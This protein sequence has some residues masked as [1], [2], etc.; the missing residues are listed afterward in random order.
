MLQNNLIK[1][2]GMIFCKKFVIS[3]I[4]VHL[5]IRLLLKKCYK[6]EIFFFKS[7]IENKK[8]GKKCRLIYHVTWLFYASLGSNAFLLNLNLPVLVSISNNFT[9]TISPSLKIPSKFSNRLCEISEICNKPCLP[10]IN[11]TNAP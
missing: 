2:N 9:L 8:V 5:N 11:S 10:G 3:S 4:I 7:K 6:N 1:K